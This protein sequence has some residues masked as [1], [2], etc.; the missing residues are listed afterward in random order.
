MNDLE[1]SASSADEQPKD[2]I[3]DF[4]TSLGSKCSGLKSLSVHF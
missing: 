1:G 4:T 2:F 3:Q